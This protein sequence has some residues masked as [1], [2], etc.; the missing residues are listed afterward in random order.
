MDS[1]NDSYYR[2]NWQNLNNALYTNRAIYSE[3]IIFETHRFDEVKVADVLT[4]ASPNWRTAGAYKRVSKSEN[5]RVL[6]E[7]ARWMN[8]VLTN[9]G[10]D[11]F[12]AG[13]WGCG[14]FRQDPE[15]VATVF[16]EE[17]TYP[18]KLIFAIPPGRNYNAFK[19]IMEK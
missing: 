1:F 8:Q 16:L 9:E 17:L 12:I 13:A 19:K 11:T 3:N 18:K 10:V 7:R 6:R 14:V 5:N 15:F 2:P 4:C